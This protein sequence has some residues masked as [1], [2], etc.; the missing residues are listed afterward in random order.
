MINAVDSKYA[1]GRIAGRLGG[2]GLANRSCD[3][4]T[5]SRFFGECSTV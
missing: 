4:A 2:R 3:L 5:V 1:I